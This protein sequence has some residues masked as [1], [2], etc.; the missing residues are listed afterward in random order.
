MMLV[1]VS[2]SEV[3]VALAMLLGVA[4]IRL[5]KPWEK[6]LRDMDV[7]LTTG[8]KHTYFAIGKIYFCALVGALLAWAIRHSSP[9][10]WAAASLGFIVLLVTLYAAVDQTYGPNAKL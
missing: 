1:L 8:Q 9:P 3:A 7:Q 4:L 2:Q 10:A 5:T 6:K